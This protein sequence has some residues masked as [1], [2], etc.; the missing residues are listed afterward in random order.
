METV[1]QSRPITECSKEIKA[2][3]QPE[4]VAFKSTVSV[5]GEA[6]ET[7]EGEHLV[8]PAAPR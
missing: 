6:G 8:Q 4:P 1:A 5:T 7:V 3:V 2:A